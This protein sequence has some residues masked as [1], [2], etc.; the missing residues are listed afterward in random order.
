M[1]SVWS[2][3]WPTR[4]WLFLGNSFG[5]PTRLECV[6]VVLSAALQAQPTQHGGI[7]VNQ[8]TPVKKTYQTPT[9]TKYQRL[10]KVTLGT[11]SNGANWLLPGN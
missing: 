7:I 9:L 10:Q 4:D 1:S 11:L 6:T 3:N 5:T 2:S 8:N